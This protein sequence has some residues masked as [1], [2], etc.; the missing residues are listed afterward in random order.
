LYTLLIF[1]AGLT[2]YSCKKDYAVKDNEEAIK[3][4]STIYPKKITGDFEIVIRYETK[5]APEKWKFEKW[6]TNNDLLEEQGLL[7]QVIIDSAIEFYNQAFARY[8]TR[9]QYVYRTIFTKEMSN[10]I[11]ESV[12]HQNKFD[13]WDF[14]NRKTGLRLWITCKV[15]L[16]EFRVHR[17]LEINQDGKPIS[18]VI[19]YYEKYYATPFNDMIY[20]KNKIING[21]VIKTNILAKKYEGEPT[22]LIY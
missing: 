5:E 3:L 17:I 1:L 10:I 15:I 4:L 8:E 21:E 20:M 7:K 9:R 18:S 13:E 2:F 6:K 11:I 22:K 16:G 12:R 19:Y 14:L